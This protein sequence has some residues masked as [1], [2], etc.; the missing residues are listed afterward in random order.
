MVVVN[1]VGSSRTDTVR[2]SE[3]GRGGRL[4]GSVASTVLNGIT[5]VGENNIDTLESGTVVDTSVSDKRCGTSQTGSTVGDGYDGAVLVHLSVTEVVEPRPCEDGFTR[6]CVRWDRDVEVQSVNHA[7]TDDGVDNVPRCSLVVGHHELTTSSAVGSCADRGNA[8]GLTS[9]PA[10]D[11]VHAGRRVVNVS[12]ARVLGAICRQRARHGVIDDRAGS[13]GVVLG[14]KRV[15]GRDL[16]VSGGDGG[17]SAGDEDGFGE[18]FVEVV[19][20][21]V[22]GCAC[23]RVGDW[24]G[25][26]RVCV[27][28]LMKLEGDEIPDFDEV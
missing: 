20:L 8:D 27:V 9:V 24:V 2:S 25:Q 16:H 23:E 15:R 6:W 1:D 26:K 12:F 5:W 14:V 19:G 17:E 28:K 7:A 13:S 3:P 21:G 18:H 4:R 10:R 22:G 11:G